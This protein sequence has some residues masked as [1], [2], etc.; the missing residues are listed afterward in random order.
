M[1]LPCRHLARP[2]AEEGHFTKVFSI[3]KVRWYRNENDYGRQQVTIIVDSHCN[4]ACNHKHKAGVKTCQNISRDTASS[5]AIPIAQIGASHDQVG[6]VGRQ[7]RNHWGAVLKKEKTS[8]KL[9]PCFLS[10]IFQVSWDQ[11]K[12]QLGIVSCA[13]APLYNLYNGYDCWLP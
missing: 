1:I 5:P 11:M 3:G 4:D 12:P 6:L 8:W 2:C 10:T 13:C 9:L 7:C